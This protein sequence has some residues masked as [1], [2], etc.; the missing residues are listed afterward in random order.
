MPLVFVQKQL[1]IFP[2]VLPLKNAKLFL[3]ECL[4][5]GKVLFLAI[6]CEFIY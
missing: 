3:N 4:I 1:G 5:L 2:G 6:S